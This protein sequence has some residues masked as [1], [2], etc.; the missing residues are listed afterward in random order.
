MENKHF[1]TRRGVRMVYRW[2]GPESAPPLLFSHS[3]GASMAMW[4]PQ[5]DRLQERFRIL[6]H[7]HE[8]HG[9]S[10]LASSGEPVRIEDIARDTVDLLDHCGLRRVRF[11]GLSLGGMVGLW[12]AIHEPGRLERM[13]ISNTAARI[14]NT[15]LLRQRIGQIR[16]KGL[17]GIEES[18]LGR[19][20]TPRFQKAS[21]DTVEAVRAMFRKT[22]AEGYART[23]EAV[24]SLNLLDGLTEIRAPTLVIAGREDQATPPE[25]NRLIAEQI[26]GA[27]YREVPAAHMTNIEVAEEYTALVAEFLE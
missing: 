27:V 23:A 6:L 4:D 9:A 3:L 17:D 13:V 8:G 14:A 21:A 10:G 25:W 11:C 19:W 2:V 7:D 5:V 1:E 24:C 15:D 18:V 12:L 20:F 16:E 26:P 22:T